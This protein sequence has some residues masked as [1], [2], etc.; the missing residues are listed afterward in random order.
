MIKT[1][2]VESQVGDIIVEKNN[3]VQQQYSVHYVGHSVKIGASK[4]LHL[5]E[6][7]IDNLEK[8]IKEIKKV[9]K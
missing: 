9:R 4:I 1:T 7:D 5:S 2:K 8:A 3:R 6:E